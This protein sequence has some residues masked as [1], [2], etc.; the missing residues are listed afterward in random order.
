VSVL[1]ARRNDWFPGRVATARRCDRRT[2]TDFVLCKDDLDLSRIRRLSPHATPRTRSR[3]PSVPAVRTSPDATFE[4]TA[5]L[6]R[7]PTSLGKELVGEQAEHIRRLALTFR[8]PSARFQL[9][10]SS[11]ARASRISRPRYEQNHVLQLH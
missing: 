11:A 8:L 2:G 6:I 1:Y 3:L 9:R 10:S 5:G 4:A 7:N